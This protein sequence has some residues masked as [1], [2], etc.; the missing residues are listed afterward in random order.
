MDFWYCLSLSRWSLRLVDAELNKING[1]F[2]IPE[3][4]PVL[5][6]DLWSGLACPHPRPISV[7]RA[8]AESKVDVACRQI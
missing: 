7:H 6:G 2:I 1:E 3:D 5:G 8:V 4:R